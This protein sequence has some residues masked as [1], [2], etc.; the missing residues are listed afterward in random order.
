MNSKLLWVT[1]LAVLLGFAAG[2]LVANSLNRSKINELLA[3]KSGLEKTRPATPTGGSN[4]ELTNQEISEKIAE[5]E[6]NPNDF[7]FQKGLGL[8]LYRYAAKKQDG[9]LL[10]KVAKLLGRAHSL[11]GDDYQVIVS[12]GNV[13]FDLGQI[14][15]DSESNLKAREVYEK[16]LAKNPKDINVITDLGL[17]YLLTQ[18]DQ[19]VSR[20]ISEL[21][22]ALRQRPKHER[23]LQYMT[24]AHLEV[25]NLEEATIYLAKLKDVNPKNSGLAGLERRM[26]QISKQ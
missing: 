18:K 4:P 17:T 21:E 15:K 14:N 6:K 25:D 24:Q 16:A 20:A 23:A 11:N 13:Y 8:A 7:A 26:L 10:A 9:A 5:A 12:L 2:F 22:K 1:I 19:D 3:E